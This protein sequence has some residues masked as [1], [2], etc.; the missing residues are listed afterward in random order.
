MTDLPILSII[1]AI[2]IITLLFL[3][4]LVNYGSKNNN[5]IYARSITVLG[6]ILTFISSLYLL[7]SF[8][9]S[10][11]KYQFIESYDIFNIKFLQL[12][13]A[14]D[15]IALC[16]VVLTTLLSLLVIFYSV[17]RVKLHIKNYLLNF[18]LLEICLLGLFCTTNLLLF[19][20]FFEFVLIPMYLIIGIWGGENKSYAAIKFFL[21]TFL[22]SLF[23]LVPII[24]LGLQFNDLDLQN[25]S[26]LT[27][28]LPH[29]TQ[30]YLWW[31]AFIAFAVKTPMIPLHTWLPDAHVQAPTGGSVMLA[32]ILLKIGGY[33]LLRFCLQLFPVI[34][35]EYQ[36]FVI[37]LSLVAIIYS[38][39]VAYGQKDMKKLIAYSSIAHMG[40]STAALFT[41]T[42]VGIS[43]AVFQMLS[44]GLISAGLFFVVGMLY[45]RIH[46]KEIASYGGVA[47]KM[48]IMAIF[49]MLFTLANIGLPG[50]S[51]F[52]G[53][54]LSLVSIFEYS[55]IY[56]SFACLGVVLSSIYMLNL[57]S[58]VMLGPIL[59][60]KVNKMIDITKKEFLV[61]F[62]II[63]LILFMGIFPNVVNDMFFSRTIYME[64]NIGEGL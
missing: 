56:A 5:Y 30:K 40:Y 55:K 45:D 18:L 15:S 29:E 26:V 10:N 3:L 62:P 1:L 37:V 53:E 39:L 57:Y 43:A 34:S 4:T 64:I 60:P 35:F 7:F 20:I 59:N 52:I 50:T 24:Y 16:F 23:V 38:S 25:L 51:G 61:L 27:K 49:F 44:H 21:Y 63:V 6:A 32:A 13:L 9:F 17:G 58:A 47:A 19:Y 48:P 31:A 12:N 28:K 42:A 11:P 54:L 8:D 22:A 2:P 36:N 41:M 14:V 46:T 33:G